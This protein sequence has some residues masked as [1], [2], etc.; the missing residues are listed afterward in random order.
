M[1]RHADSRD[2][3]DYVRD[4]FP[5]P[6]TE[7]DAHVYISHA[8]SKPRTEDFAIVVDG[9][10]VGV[11]GYVPGT[12]VERIGA[13][14]GYWIGGGFRNRGIVTDALR[15]VSGHIFRTTGISHLH[16]PVFGF[17][18]ASM[19]V[20]EKGGYTRAGV[21]RSAAIKNGRLTDLHI[22]ELLKT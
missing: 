3:W 12:D 4:Y 21:L 8:R 6:Y 17:N 10:A 16:A 1:A 20:L 5:S 11:I 7:S 13:E 18:H 22:F 9:A 14:I 15:R 19:R 2:V